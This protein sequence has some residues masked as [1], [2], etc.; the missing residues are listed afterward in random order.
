[1]FGENNLWDIWNR[2]GLITKL[3]PRLWIEVRDGYIGWPQGIRSNPLVCRSIEDLPLWSN[4]SHMISSDCVGST[5][6][7]HIEYRAIFGQKPKQNWKKKN[8]VSKQR[9]LRAFS[10]SVFRDYYFPFGL[11]C[12]QTY[13]FSQA[14]P[15][16]ALASLQSPA[17]A[18]CFAFARVFRGSTLHRFLGSRFFINSLEELGFC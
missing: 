4:K 12:S 1:M 13:L 8:I 10:L 17:L 15:R 3:G 7:T 2:Y 14:S 9:C 5:W 6:L 18:L 11:V 16:L